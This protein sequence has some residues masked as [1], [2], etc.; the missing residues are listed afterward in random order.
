MA[1]VEQGR[2]RTGGLGNAVRH[3]M[4]GKLDI[5]DRPKSLLPHLAGQKRHGGGGRLR[6]GAAPREGGIALQPVF[7][8]EV[9]QGEAV[10][11]HHG[12]LLHGIEKRPE[13]PV[14][15]LQLFHLRR[16]VGP[17]GRRV[18]RV[19]LGH[20]LPHGAGDGGSVHRRG[21]HVLVVFQHLALPVG[22]VSVM[23]VVI[24]MAV[25]PVGHA[26]QRVLL[27]QLHAVRHFHGVHAAV[28]GLQQRVHPRVGLTAH[29]D[30]QRAG[31]HVQDVPGRRLVAVALRPRR[32]QQL[33]PGQI[34]ADGAGQIVGREHRGRHQRAAVVRLR[35]GGR[36]G[37]ARGQQRRGRQ[38]RQQ[39]QDASFHISF[40]SNLRMVFIFCSIT[41]P[42]RECKS[43]PRP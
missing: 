40:L 2:P 10:A 6:L 8:R 36:R 38:R 15:L 34:P 11:E 30:E 9:P 26:L 7:I 5:V 19:R 16:R 35:R 21:P 24:V 28:H 32:Q 33:H 39:A 42:R 22:A 14:Q 17:I 37:A 31:P 3:Q 23:I 13:R 1:G 43:Q 4:V 27:L 12:L 18:G 29:V 20:P 41:R 25:V